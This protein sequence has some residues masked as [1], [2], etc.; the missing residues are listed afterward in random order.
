MAPVAGHLHVHDSFGRPY[1]MT[2]FYHP[3]EATA[4]GIGDLHLPIG[5]GDIPW[6]EIFSELTFLPDTMLVME[7]T[8]ERFATEQADSLARALKLV[9]RVNSRRLAAYGVAAR[10]VTPVCSSDSERLDRGIDRVW[11]IHLQ[12][13][14]VAREARWL[15]CADEDI[16]NNRL[17]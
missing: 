12:Q 14:H 17:P 15:G 2:K 9:D 11:Y 4:L 7:I 5:W 1:S 13:F 3:A 6:E 10:A 16:G 8:G